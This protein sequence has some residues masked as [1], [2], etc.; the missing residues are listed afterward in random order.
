MPAARP[1]AARHYEGAASNPA[2][3]QASNRHSSGAA[4]GEAAAPELGA[5][6]NHAAMVS[7]RMRAAAKADR[8]VAQA[9]AV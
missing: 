5:D 1:L 7:E 8:T 4:R 9:E 2:G 6:P 3:A